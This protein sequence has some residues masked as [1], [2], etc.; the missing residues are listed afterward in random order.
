M[1]MSE[2]Q[3]KYEMV[4]AGFEPTLISYEIWISQLDKWLSQKDSSYTK[5]KKR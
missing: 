4:T 2:C 5:F 1:K 3:K